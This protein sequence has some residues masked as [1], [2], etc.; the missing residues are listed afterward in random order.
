[1]ANINVK[2]I[3]EA[4]KNVLANIDAD[5]VLYTK[6]KTDG[7]VAYEVKPAD[8]LDWFSKQL[9]RNAASALKSKER[10]AQK[11]AEANME[12]KTAILKAFENSEKESLTFSEIADAVDDINT[13]Q[14]ARAVVVCYPDTFEIIDGKKKKEVKVIG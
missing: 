7:E 8:V 3:N 12:F 14:K 11:K 2:D 13:W 4:V 5:D 6:L 1:M 10:A 9:N